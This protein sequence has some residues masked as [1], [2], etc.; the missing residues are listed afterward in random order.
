MACEILLMDTHR[1]K[2]FSFDFFQPLKNLTT[3]LTSQTTENWATGRL[4]PAG[5]SAGPIL[6]SPRHQEEGLASSPAV[7][8]LS[9]TAEVSSSIPGQ[10]MKIPKA[11]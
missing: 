5:Q 1:L 8:T 6:V 7:R 11:A 2:H 10:G 9:F 4:W 3:V